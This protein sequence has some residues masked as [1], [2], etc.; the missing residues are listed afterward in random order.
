MQVTNAGSVPKVIAAKG[1]RSFLYR[2]TS[3]PVRCM[4]SAALPP[5]PQI[6]SLP[7]LRRL[8]AQRSTAHSNPPSNSRRVAS[9]ARD[10]SN[11]S[12]K[13]LIL[14]FSLTRP[15]R[16]LVYRPWP[17]KAPLYRQYA[18]Q[19]WRAQRCMPQAPAAMPLCVAPAALAPKSDRRGASQGRQSQSV[20]GSRHPP[21][22]PMRVPASCRR[23]LQSGGQPHL[24][25]PQPAP[26]EL[27]LPTDRS[28]GPSGYAS[29]SFPVDPQFGAHRSPPFL[30]P[31]F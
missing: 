2:P 6:S 16:P 26:P 1:R 23:W 11:E 17:R 13:L 28:V 15:Q 3:S 10:S 27:H 19:A 29:D 31:L 25:F 7:P 4:A 5:F 20:P 14:V 9:I 22:S 8:A 24:P 30:S 12:V 18:L 21:I